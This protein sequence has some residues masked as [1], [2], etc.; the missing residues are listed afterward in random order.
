MEKNLL[1]ELTQWVSEE[2][3][4]NRFSDVG[5]I[6]SVHEGRITRFEKLLKVKLKSETGGR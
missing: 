1:Q 4:K 5:Y 2:I 6:L 3:E